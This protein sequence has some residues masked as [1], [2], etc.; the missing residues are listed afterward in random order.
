[1]LYDGSHFWSI[2]RRS[3]NLPLFYNISRNDLT[4]LNLPYPRCT[5]YILVRMLLSA[6]SEK[7]LTPEQQAAFE[8]LENAVKSCR[9]TRKTREAVEMAKLHPDIALVKDMWR[10]K[11]VVWDGRKIDAWAS[12]K[13]IGDACRDAFGWEVTKEKGDW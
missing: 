1:M 2:N 4:L 6:E 11:C 3:F 13:S 7:T 12:K 10:V 8:K 9:P 5:L